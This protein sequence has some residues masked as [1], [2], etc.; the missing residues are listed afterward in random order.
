MT[1]MNLRRPVSYRISRSF[2]AWIV[3]GALANLPLEGLESKPAQLFVG[4]AGLAHGVSSYWRDGGQ[5]ISAPGIYMIA[6]GL[7]IFFPA[8]YLYFDDPIIHGPVNYIAAVNVAYWSQLLLYFLFWQPRPLRNDAVVPIERTGITTWGIW[9]GLG[10][11]IAGVILVRTPLSQYGFDDG[12]AFAGITLLSVASL[13]RPRRVKLAAYGLIAVSFIIYMEFVFAGFGRL[14]IGALG[15][16]IAATAAHR[17]RGRSVKLALLI[18]FPPVLLYLAAARVKFSGSLNPNQSANVTGLESAIGPFVRFAE[19]MHLEAADQITHTGLH[20]FFAAAVAL[21]PRQIWPTKPVGFG[22]E[23]ADFFR[24]DLIGRGHSEAAL[25]HGEW[26]F[27]FGFPGLVLMVGILGLL[28]RWLDNIAQRA[29]TIPGMSRL[30]LLKIA[31]LLILAASLTD[32][33]WGG[34]FTYV[35]RTGPRLICLLV[36]FLALGWN[37]SN[38]AVT[39]PG[40]GSGRAGIEGRDPRSRH[41]TDHGRV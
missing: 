6:S 11:V 22:A 24:P 12:A 35:S 27:A 17:W 10:L 18:S 9:A 1:T 7:F 37:R 30:D 32:L 23:L 3:V 39:L 4:V 34:A 40:A 28:V 13:R 15:I 33:I 16:V 5:R 31:A 36:A 2:V 29:G 20:T 25:F 21:V 38:E 26:I 14:Q 19:L 8:I 41:R